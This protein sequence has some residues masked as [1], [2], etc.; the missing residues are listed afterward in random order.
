VASSVASAPAHT[1]C[2]G[3]E[4]WYLTGLSAHFIEGSAGC[5][6]VQH[7][8]DDLVDHLHRPVRWGQIASLG[9]AWVLV[10]APTREA[11]AGQEQAHREQ[12]WELSEIGTWAPDGLYHGLVGKCTVP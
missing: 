7:T 2:I 6:A 3:R 9:C 5:I 4:S 1:R 12:A 8:Q 11:S 10:Q